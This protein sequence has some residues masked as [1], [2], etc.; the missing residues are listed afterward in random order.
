MKRFAV[1]TVTAL[2]LAFGAE[3]LAQQ[4]A[5][6]VAPAQRTVIKEY[7]VKEK[8]KPITFKEKI[9]VGTALPAEVQLLPAP[10]AWGPTFTKYQYVYHDNHVV[11]V[12]PTSRKVIQI[13]D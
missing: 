5:I 9:V 4:I 8:V 1:L 12:E 3:A 11:L 7:V 10:T 2:S 6:E 13:I